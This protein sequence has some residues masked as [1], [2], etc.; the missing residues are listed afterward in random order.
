[1]SKITSG[2][3]RKVFWVPTDEVMKRCMYAAR[4][5]ATRN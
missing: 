1:M 3:I 5:R 4:K 2:T